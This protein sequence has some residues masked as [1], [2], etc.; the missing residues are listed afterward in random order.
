MTYE[1]IRCFKFAERTLSV[2]VTV[3]LVAVCN[4]GAIVDTILDTISICKNAR[5]GLETVLNRD[6]DSTSIGRTNIELR[7]VSICR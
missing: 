6:S 7:T 5:L 3:D 2:I 4:I 1:S